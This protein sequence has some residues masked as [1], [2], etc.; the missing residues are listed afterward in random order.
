MPRSLTPLLAALLVMYS[1]FQM[2]I[3]VVAPLAGELALTPFQLS[4]VFTVTSVT[5]TVASLL[6]GLLF[7][8]AG[9]RPVLFAGLLLCV[10]GPA[11]YAAAVAFSLDETLTPDVAFALVLLFRS[12]LF[13]AGLAAVLVTALAV[14][15]LSTH[16]ETARTR[17]IG[18]VGAAQSLGTVI[19]PVVGGALAVASV[20]LPLYVAPVV[21]LLLALLVLVTIKPLA[22]QEGEPVQAQPLQLVPA[23][24][25]GFFLHVSLGMAQVVVVYL[26]SERLRESTGSAEGV[27]F[28]S[29]IGLVLTQGL[30]VPLLKWSPVRLMR[31]G[32]PVS[33]VGYALLA[34]APSS[35]LMALAFLVVAVGVGL[36]LTGFAAAASLGVGPRHQGLVAGLVTTTSGL[37]FIVAPM[38]SALLYEVG[39]LAPVLAAALAALVATGLS[40]V[41]VTPQVSR[42]VG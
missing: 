12:V 29:A 41:P 32:S 36:A 10:A 20:W 1:V 16:G 25:T 5:I 26:S 38:L 9:P 34:V 30:L 7:D 21:A 2:L 24:G 37:T 4:L 6:W 13:G 11:G 42:P 28:A 17:A 3:G 19:G 18:F 23:F 31:I 39:P 33:V 27:L 22:A 35:A 14:A 8:A 40:F 15:G